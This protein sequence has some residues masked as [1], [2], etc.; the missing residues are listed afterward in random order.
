MNESVHKLGMDSTHFVNAC[1]LDEE[2]HYTTARDI[3]VMARAWASAPV[4]HR[5]HHRLAGY[6]PA[7]EPNW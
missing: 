6:P 1:G 5:L 7:A 2:G 3:A 4:H